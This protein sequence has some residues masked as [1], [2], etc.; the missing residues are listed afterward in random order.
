MH[1]LPSNR[2]WALNRHVQTKL[3]T[4]DGVP[5]IPGTS[6]WR[7][8]EFPLP[9]FQGKDI[10]IHIQKGENSCLRGWGDWVGCTGCPPVGAGLSIFMCS[11]TGNSR[12]QCLEGAG[13][14]APSLEGA[15]IPAPSLSEKEHANIKPTGR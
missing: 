9:H 11:R 2:G 12:H 10:L 13:I 8:R 5:G 6:A 14:S 1:G 4:L 15:E 3:R 7:E